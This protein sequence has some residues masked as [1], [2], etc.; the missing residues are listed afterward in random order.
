MIGENKSI[1][2]LRMG[3]CRIKYLESLFDGLTENVVMTKLNV[4]RNGFD[5]K[6]EELAEMLR[7]NQ[8]LK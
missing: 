8:T 7:I 3:E 6:Y 4:S 5:G 2:D 1:K